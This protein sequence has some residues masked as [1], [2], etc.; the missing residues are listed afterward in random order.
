ME[1]L[2]TEFTSRG[3]ILR[4]TL[5]MP[6]KAE[7]PPVVVMAHGFGGCVSFG[8]A[9]F[10]EHFCAQGMAVLTFDYRGFGKSDGEPRNWVSPSRHLWDWKA[11]VAHARTL[12]QVDRSRVALWG[13]SFS[14]GHVLVTAADIP[15]VK[16][17]V[18]QVP[19]VDGRT[20]LFLMPPRLLARSMSAA[21]R[22]LARMA[23]GK[24]ALYVPLV[25]APGQL[26]A[27]TQPGCVEE[28][29]RLVPDEEKANANRVTA[30]TFLEV[31][32]YRPLARAQDVQC[33]VLVIMAEEDNLIP[34][35]SVQQAAGL[36]PNAELVSLPVSH[37]DVYFGKVFEKV[38]KKEAAFLK[39]HLK[40]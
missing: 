20:T 26:G 9:P 29:M 1:K 27:L 25:A 24:P 13:T 32:A 12:P 8:L 10:A 17:V 19:F 11:A 37:F 22:D 16:C 39:K 18:C 21:V 2:A 6:D 36:L 7:N 30:R 14:G 31:P 4:G 3:T 28:F 35:R 5:H 33:P 40:P 15:A 34:S 38:V 23:M